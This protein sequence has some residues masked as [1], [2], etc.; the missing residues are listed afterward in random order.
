M[1]RISST[2]S[3]NLCISCV[4]GG[5]FRQVSRDFAIPATGQVIPK[6][7]MC[8]LNFML[9]NY[10]AE[11]FADPDSFQPERQATP[12]K[13]MKELMTP[14]AI[15]L[16]SCIGRFLATAEIDTIVSTLVSNFDFSVA[17]EGDLDF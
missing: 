9:E 5:V 17:E 11:I 4:A 15:G 2:L 3:R 1:C 16:R 6:G 10:N 13:A 8:V 14:F 7:A 12:T